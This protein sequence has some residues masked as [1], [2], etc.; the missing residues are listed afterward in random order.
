[1]AAGSTYPFQITDDNG[2][3][4]LDGTLTFT[5]SANQP[6]PQ[7]SP[8]FTGIVTAPALAISGLTGAVT[9]SRYVGGT[10]T[11]APTTGTFAVG[12]FVISANGATWVCTVAGTPGTWVQ[13]NSGTY[14]PKASPTFT[15]LA[16]SP[17]WATTAITSGALPT[18][19]LSSATGAQLSTARDVDSATP[20]TY[21]GT[22]NVGS[23]AVALS[24]DNSTYSTLYTESLAAAVNNVGAI[25]LPVNLHVPKSW[26]VKLTVVHASIGTTTYW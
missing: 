26:Y 14:A 5:D 4:R 17:A 9:A 13:M 22:L 6:G 3:E 11:V 10:A 2:I 19:T 24:P 25:V 15:V 12:D 18:A 1:M 7:A 16:T 21:D 20:I 8:T 23:V